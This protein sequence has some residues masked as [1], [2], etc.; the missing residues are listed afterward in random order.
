[1]RRASEYL[2]EARVSTNRVQRVRLYRNFQNHFV[3]EVPAIPLFYPVYS[4]GVS[5]LVRGVSIGPLYQTSDRFTTLPEWFL[6]ARS[7]LD[8]LEPTLQPQQ[9][10]NTP[11]PTP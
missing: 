7:Q 10:T 4:Y 6:V 8:E 3:N 11:V 5:S 1:D 9:S 2:E